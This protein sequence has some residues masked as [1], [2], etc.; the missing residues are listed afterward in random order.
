MKNN[1]KIILIIFF[2][3]T[4]NK[5]AYTQNAYSK[6]IYNAYIYN[7]MGDW[8]KVCTIMQKNTVRDS[9]YIFEKLNY[10]YGFIGNCL[11]NKNYLLAKKY[12]NIFNKD[13]L[14][15]ETNKYNK[16]LIYS[17]KSAAYAFSIGINNYLAPIYGG[18]NKEYAE[19]AINKDKNNYLAYI[20]LANNYRYT[21][22]LF[23]GSLTKALSNYLKSEQI[24]LKNIKENDWNYLW[25]LVAISETYFEIE[26]YDKAL[27]YCNKALKIE[28]N[29]NYAKNILLKQI[30]TNRKL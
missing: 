15:A 19:L 25:L 20:Q 1:I 9:L 13:I 23:G 4:I 26:E 27:N 2:F 18:K 24:Y 12:L 14:Y 5:I 17:Y 29:F 11:N 30:E 8:E 21:P 6:T 22:Y 3:L 16:S 28:P 10:L 7:K